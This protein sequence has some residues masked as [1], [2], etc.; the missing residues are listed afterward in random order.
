MRLTPLSSMS[1]PKQESLSKSKH[2]RA[3]GYILPPLRTSASASSGKGK[4]KRPQREE[5]TFFTPQS[6][7]PRRE[8][9]DADRDS[10]HQSN[11]SLG[12]IQVP[13]SDV[14]SS[15]PPL[16][17]PSVSEKATCS[18]NTS[19][20]NQLV[21][22]SSPVAQIKA[23]QTHKKAFATPKLA[24]SAKPA[25]K[26]SI[27]SIGNSERKR[28][29][30]AHDGGHQDGHKDIYSPNV[31]VGG[32]RG[33]F[34]RSVSE[35]VA[36][37]RTII[38]VADLSAGAHLDLKTWG[39]NGSS[40]ITSTPAP[41]KNA[42]QGQQY[43]ATER[44]FAPVR[45]TPTLFM[46]GDPTAKQQRSG[47]H[48]ASLRTDS[49]ASCLSP[50][51]GA[52]S[53]SSWSRSQSGIL[54][55]MCSRKELPFLAPTPSRA[56]G[57][58][59]KS[60]QLLHEDDD[61]LKQDPPQSKVVEQEDM[62]PPPSEKKG[63]SENPSRGLLDLLPSDP[64]SM[65]FLEVDS[66]AEDAPLEGDTDGDEEDDD[67]V[68]DQTDGKSQDKKRKL[69]TSSSLTIAEESGQRVHR[70]STPP[71]SDS[72]KPIL[73]RFA[74]LDYYAGSP[75]KRKGLLGDESRRLSGLASARRRLF[76][77]HLREQARER[78]MAKASSRAARKRARVSESVGKKSALASM[79]RQDASQSDD[80]PSVALSSL[81]PT[82]TSFYETG[83]TEA[84]HA[85]SSSPT[86]ALRR[87]K[88]STT[89]TET[90]TDE[91]AARLLLGLFGGRS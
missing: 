10:A 24:N 39:Y 3:E 73:R 74:S 84:R 69:Q 47:R 2:E 90:E 14:R 36:G 46:S 57:S 53:G 61:A 20:S 51:I 87:S 64:P 81:P 59:Q 49:S 89:T 1:R 29:A 16:A 25:R 19:R 21:E 23:L 42:Q 60:N 22:A 6:K 50:T 91:E 76:D 40:I 7:Q 55:E 72:D 70:G 75:S 12:P 37:K 41:R 17:T 88:S 62:L 77:A 5:D 82:Q 13:T 67:D 30:A 45:S 56:S 66:D 15:S 83:N 85:G 43:A 86:K 18:Q 35:Y 8:G 71:L 54:D 78:R 58:L 11:Q 27:I 65:G 28:K 9:A 4:G 34:Q 38:G 63:E 52:K 32:N 80:S 68:P 33:L 44:K 31:T 48:Q 26:D 79:S